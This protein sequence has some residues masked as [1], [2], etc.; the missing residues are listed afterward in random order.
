MK[1]RMVLLLAL[2]LCFGVA[3]AENDAIDNWISDMTQQAEAQITVSELKA[4]ACADFPD[5]QLIGDDEY[6]SDMWEGQMAHHCE[7]YMLRV[8]QGKLQLRELYVLMNPV[9]SGEAVPWEV[10]DY[11]S[12]PLTAEAEARLAAMG[13]SAFFRKYSNTQLSEEALPGCAAFLLN[14]GEHL[15]DLLIYPDF[16]VATVEDD[17]GRMGLR[18]A[19]WDGSEYTK[20]TATA[21]G[22]KVWVNEI[23]SWN[24]GLEV[25]A[26]AELGVYCDD[27]GVWRVNVVTDGGR[28]FLG[29]D[30]LADSQGE[31]VYWTN[32]WYTF[33]VPTFP[34]ELD[35]M[36]FAALPVS[37]EEA[38]PLLDPS[39]HAC[40]KADGTPLHDAPGGNVLGIAYARLTGRVISEQDG[41]VQLQIGSEDAGLA[42][43]FRADDLAY[44]AEVNEVDCTFPTYEMP[45]DMAEDWYEMWLIAEVP[46]GWLAQVDM[47]TVRF[48]SAE[49]IVR[50]G[51]P[52]DD[53]G[54]LEDAWY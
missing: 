43:W 30:Y 49:E 39:G 25:W 37:T 5:W 18:I 46:G 12:V 29:E 10:W 1:K 42:V 23:H 50:I 48:V 51:P 14:E 40:T 13:P 16:L 22:E 4:A 41:W 35:G 15:T 28:Y 45:E 11:A 53:W 36:D 32:A 34:V 47:D 3:Q 27:S 8:A 24:D 17:A 26:T 54:E 6:W 9:K 44:G 52:C 31:G 38:I 2:L 19:H 7:L 20:V 33:G 21:M